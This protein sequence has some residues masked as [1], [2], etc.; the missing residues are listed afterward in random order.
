M[1]N[2]SHKSQVKRSLDTDGRI[3]LLMDLEK[4]GVEGMDC[5][6]MAEDMVHRRVLVNAIVDLWVL[7][8]PER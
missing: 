3:I 1:Q 4:I 8:K 2:F 5:I 7:Q 6:D